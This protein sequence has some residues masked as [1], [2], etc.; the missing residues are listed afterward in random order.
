MIW[1]LESSTSHGLCTTK[2]NVHTIWIRTSNSICLL[3]CQRQRLG[4][5]ININYHCVLFRGLLPGMDVFLSHCYRTEEFFNKKKKKTNGHIYECHWRFLA[6]ICWLS[7]HSSRRAYLMVSPWLAASILQQIRDRIQ[8]AAKKT[9]ASDGFFSF[10]ADWNDL[11]EGVTH[12][13]RF[14]HAIKMFSD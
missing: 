9:I 6:T 4:C 10:I 11:C 12:S 14:Q 7:Q 3:E 2:T 13:L 8:R 5:T 1:L